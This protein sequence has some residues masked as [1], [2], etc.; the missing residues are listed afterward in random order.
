MKFVFFSLIFSATKYVNVH[1]ALQTVN[2]YKNIFIKTNLVSEKYIGRPSKALTRRTRRFYQL[3]IIFNQDEVVQIYL[4]TSSQSSRKWH[5]IKKQGKKLLDNEGL[6]MHTIFK[7]N[8]PTVCRLY[9][10]MRNDWW[11]CPYQMI[12]ILPSIQWSITCTNR[13]TI[14]DRMQW[15]VN[16]WGTLNQLLGDLLTAAS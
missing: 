8:F 5:F 14:V 3:I 7:E 4:Q 9:S 10:N 15:S 6:I 11:V 1:L 2:W 16:F 13:N 12:S